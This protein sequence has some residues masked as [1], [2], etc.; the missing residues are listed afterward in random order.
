MNRCKHGLTTDT[1]AVCAGLVKTDGELM[2][3]WEDFVDVEFDLT[4]EKAKKRETP[5][6]DIWIQQHKYALKQKFYKKY[7]QYPPI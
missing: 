4:F 3:L 1:C 6:K 2:L 7:G 5:D